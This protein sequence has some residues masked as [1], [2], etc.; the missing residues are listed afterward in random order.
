MYHE[1]TWAHPSLRKLDLENTRSRKR[2]TPTTP[3][4]ESETWQKEITWAHPSPRQ[5]DLLEPGAAIALSTNY[6]LTERA[7]SVIFVFLFSRNP[8]TLPKA[9]NYKFF[10]SFYFLDATL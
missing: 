8:N 3:T 4:S 10:S 2:A 7:N 9:R 1:I 6:K 5:L